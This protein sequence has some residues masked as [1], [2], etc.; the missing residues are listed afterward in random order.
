[1]NKEF[2]KAISDVHDATGIPR[3]GSGQR[4]IRN[5]IREGKIGLEGK[6]WIKKGS[7]ALTEK[8]FNQLVIYVKN[9]S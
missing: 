3:N 6:D 4:L 5:P 7:Y 2:P 9:N 8:F 1:M